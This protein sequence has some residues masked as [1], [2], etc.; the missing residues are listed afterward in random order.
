[1]DA[2]K[3]IGCVGTGAGVGA[4]IGWGAALATID[5][6]DIEGLVGLTLVGGIVGG[7]VGSVV[8]GRIV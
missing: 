7:I 1:M 5:F 4:F 3:I 8:A 2:L 6:D